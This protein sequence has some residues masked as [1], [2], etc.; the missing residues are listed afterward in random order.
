MSRSKKKL[1][2]SLRTG[3][4]QVQAVAA[5]QSGDSVFFLSG[6]GY[7]S[8]GNSA[9]RGYLYWPTT[10][11]RRQ[12]TTLTRN[13]ILRRIQWLYVHFGFCRRLVNGMARLLG[14]LRPLP[15]S[16]DEEWND[17]AYEALMVIMGQEEIW[18]SAGKFDA[19]MGQ[20]QD[21]ISI[22]RDGDCLGVMTQTE[23]GRARLTYYEAHQIKGGPESSGAGW[24]DGVRLNRAGKHIAYS[25]Q[26]GEDPTKFFIIDARDAIYFGNFENRG[27]VRAISVLQ[28]AVL[29]MVDVVETRGFVKAGLKN[30]ARLGVAVETDYNAPASSP[31]GGMGG[32][33]EQRTVTMPDGSQQ[34]MT[35]E[36]IAGAN[37]A[38]RL[39]PGQKIKVISDDRPSQNFQEFEKALLTDCCYAAD[40]SYQTLCDI[41]KITGPGIRFLNAELKRWITIKRYP[42]AKKMARLTVWALAKE[43]N[44]GR[45]RRPTGT[46]AKN[47]WR[48]FEWLGLAD[49]D[50]DGGRTAQATVTDLQTGQ[51]TWADQ[52]AGKGINWKKRIN[53]AI[54]E[55]VYAEQECRRQREKA[56]LPEGLINVRTV[57]PLRFGNQPAP[58]LEAETVPP[59]EGDD[60]DEEDGDPDAPNDLDPSET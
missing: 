20:V 60:D 5:T 3:A 29:N 48:A 31:V 17:E 25:V 18:D 33:V 44:S 56:N 12:M 40:L 19:F 45:L 46:A 16:S 11:T 13:E 59:K 2:P 39:Q 6:S 7:Q 52:W 10:D 38:P 24:V 4:A 8:A 27:Q 42:Q 51:T 47:W 15:N 9:N 49:M 30:H 43:M 54:Y 36:M 26:D 21:N 37:V 14:Y 34:P 23:N 55:V 53:Q 58:L 35:F 28:T 50:I 22:F 41:S 1:P 57:F 32:P